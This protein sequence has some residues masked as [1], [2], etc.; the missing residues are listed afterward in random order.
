MLAS[1]TGTGIVCIATRTVD[2][3]TAT[4]CC[5]SVRRRS[6]MTTGRMTT[7]MST[8]TRTGL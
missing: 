8:V 2:H 1:C 6:F 4:S 3:T 5:P 7:Y